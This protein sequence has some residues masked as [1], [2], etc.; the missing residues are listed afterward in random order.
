MEGRSTSIISL[1][2]LHAQ[3][4]FRT[5]QFSEWPCFTTPFWRVN[6]TT[7]APSPS[8]L[9]TAT[10][11]LGLLIPRIQ[12]CVRVINNHLEARAGQLHYNGLL[13]EYSKGSLWTPSRCFTACHKGRSVQTRP[14]LVA[15]LRDNS[16]TLSCV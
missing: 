8:G 12:V 2:R 6:Y 16:T 4:P 3:V 9:R 14:G 10:H 1:Q 13:E 15:Q 5:H 11:Q 7:I